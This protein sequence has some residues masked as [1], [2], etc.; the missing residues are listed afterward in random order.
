LHRLSKPASKPSN[1][2]DDLPS[3][4]SND[5]EDE[6]DWSSSVDDELSLPDSSNPPSD[7]DSN[8]EM[9]YEMLPRPRR[10]SWDE[11]VNPGIQRL[12]IKLPDGR[13]QETGHV[14][15]V[16]SSSSE[17]DSVGDSDDLSDEGGEPEAPKVEDVSTGARFGRP[18]VVD[19]LGT[20]SRKARIQAAKEQ[21]AGIC[22]DILA[23]PENGVSIATA[24]II[25]RLRLT[26]IL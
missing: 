1:V 4:D 19:V 21:I 20:A 10:S 5:E 12:P 26:D 6:E 11:K 22:Q 15:I 9:P 17:G 23:E 3:I 14:P 8:S 2:V 24:N 16:S 25:P 13:V 18:S 7:L